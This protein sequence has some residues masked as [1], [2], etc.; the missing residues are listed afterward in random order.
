VPL[1]DLDEVAAGVVEHCGGDGSHRRWL[2]SEDHAEF[3]KPLIF[4]LHI[5]D[6]LR[7]TLQRFGRKTTDGSTSTAMAKEI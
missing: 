6:A 5:V 7:N 4:L 2:L 1:C 3:H